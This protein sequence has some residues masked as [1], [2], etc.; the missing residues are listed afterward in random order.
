MGKVK[1]CVVTT[2][3]D[4]GHL[5][6]L[7]LAELLRKY[8]IKGTFYIPL[9]TGM[10]EKEIKKISK[11]FEIGAHT[12]SQ[13]DLTTISL[14]EAKIEILDSKTELEAIINKKVE[15][16]CY[17]E[18]HYNMQ[19]INLV[20]EAGFIG[21]RTVEQFRIGIPKNRFKMWTTIHVHPGSYRNYIKIILNKNFGAFKYIQYLKSNFVE[22][23]KC[24]LNHVYI[25]GG[26]FHLWG[27]SWEIEKFELWE[28]LEEIFNYISNK[29]IA[30][31]S[32]GE[33]IREILK[34][35]QG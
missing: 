20:K 25:H 30:Y 21:A 11:D 10:N 24:F 22:T 29:N 23:S 12:L 1:Y 18:G 19:I 3:W 13:K 31:A 35:G 15:M 28:E 7:K 5:L 6:D 9:N 34:W 33:L 26:I 8:D 2:S 27:H 17:P 32:N 4:D 14:D 16:F